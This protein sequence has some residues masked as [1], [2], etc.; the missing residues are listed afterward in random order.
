[1]PMPTVAQVN[2]VLGKN[3]HAVIR[4]A[5]QEQRMAE[6]SDR[7][8][9]EIQPTGNESV[10]GTINC[11]VVVGGEAGDQVPVHVSFGRMGFVERPV[12]VY[13]SRLSGSAEVLF[14][15]ARVDDATWEVDGAGLYRGVSVICGY[16]GTPVAATN[17]SIDYLF[18]GPALRGA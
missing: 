7:R 16:V 15:V 12:F 2:R 13:G 17:I 6:I 18:I 14:G 3:M 11:P 9:R 1:M 10:Q 5:A 4:S 8:Q